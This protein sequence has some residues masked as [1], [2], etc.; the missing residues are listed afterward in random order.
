MT[1]IRDF[2][3]NNPISR[4]KYYITDDLIKVYIINTD[5]NVIVKEYELTYES[6]VDYDLKIDSYENKL[7]YTI[8]K[9]N[10]EHEYIIKSGKRIQK[11]T[12][13]YPHKEVRFMI[14]ENGSSIEYEDPN[15][16]PEIYTKNNMD[17]FYQ[18][19]KK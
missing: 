11:D 13:D 1:L 12:D 15:S 18:K 4:Y 10:N 19:Y 17:E 6:F 8:D 3:E 2:I 9:K 5:N 14:C 7:I 16:K